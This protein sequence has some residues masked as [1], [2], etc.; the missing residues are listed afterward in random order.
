M[1]LSRS[2]VS[3]GDGAWYNTKQIPA[4]TYVCGYCGDKVSS[5]RGYWASS[6]PDGSGSPIAYI[7]ICPSCKGPTFFTPKG[8]IYPGTAP[9]NPV[10]NLPDEL[11]DLYNEARVSAAS[12]AYTG[13]VL[14]CRKMLMNIAV[15][16][17]AEEGKRFV[18]YVEYLAD[19]G[20]VP[21]NGKVWVDYIRKRGNEATHEIALMEKEDAIALITFLEMLL[22]FIYEFPSMVPP[23]TA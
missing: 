23:E 3:L 16:E 21:P 8:E 14:L 20:Y 9:G 17:G 1:A 6:K 7:R 15:T 5:N 22:R 2:S 13:A 11:S 4:K 18:E 12:G 19:K 10:S